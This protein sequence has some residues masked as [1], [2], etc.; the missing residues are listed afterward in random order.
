MGKNERGANGEECSFG[1]TCSP[2][3]I[4]QIVVCIINSLQICSTYILLYS[5]FK[6]LSI[7]D[8]HFFVR[9]S[10]RQINL[11]END[12]LASLFRKIS[13]NCYWLYCACVCSRG[14][15]IDLSVLCA[16]S[17]YV[18]AKVTIKIFIHLAVGFFVWCVFYCIYLYILRCWVI[19]DCFKRNKKQTHA[20]DGKVKKDQIKQ[21]SRKSKIKTVHVKEKTK[22]QSYYLYEV[23]FHSF[24]LRSFVFL[25]VLFCIPL[26]N[27]RCQCE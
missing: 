4:E 3:G 15:S 26:F 18:C 25:I 8:T 11:N 13:A 7:F 6:R 14:G 24:L 2:I 16:V 9:F 1:A 17:G 27:H 22:W 23:F 12:T 21:K 10:L 20:D 5:H 19:C